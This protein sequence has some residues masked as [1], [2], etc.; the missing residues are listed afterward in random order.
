[1]V[2]VGPARVNKKRLPGQGSAA[3]KMRLARFA[4]LPHSTSEKQQESDSETTMIYTHVLN[5]GPSGV[6]SPVDG[7]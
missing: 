1:M 2:A 5:R 3:I 6:R 4:V 7:L